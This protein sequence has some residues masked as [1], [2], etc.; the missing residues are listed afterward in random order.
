MVLS[1]PTTSQASPQVKHGAC[2]VG[3]TT[4][5]L[6]RAWGQGK[7]LRNFNDGRLQK[8][9]AEIS[10][11]VRARTISGLGRHRETIVRPCRDGTAVLPIPACW[12][13][14]ARQRRASRPPS[15]PWGEM[16]PRR[17]TCPRTTRPRITRWAVFLHR[18]HWYP[19]AGLDGVHRF[20]ST[21]LRHSAYRI[22]VLPRHLDKNEGNRG[23]R[24]FDEYTVH[25]TGRQDFLRIGLFR[26]TAR[27]SGRGCC[28]G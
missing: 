2:W 21:H 8:T 25:R 1:E 3:R 15:R 11:A 19:V 14:R 18:I 22:V 13:V 12:Q 7:D 6:S 26:S 9:P 20:A 16:R 17:S 4:T 5:F 28:C 27:A 10:G 23:E 24:R